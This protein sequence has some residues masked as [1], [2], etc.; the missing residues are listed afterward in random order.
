MGSA[1]RARAEAQRRA[2]GRERSHSCPGPAPPRPKPP[3]PPPRAEPPEKGR[4]RC[5]DFFAELREPLRLPA[6]PPPCPTA[7]RGARPDAGPSRTSRLTS[8]SSRSKA[9]A[10]CVR[11]AGA[12]GS[13]G[14]SMDDKLAQLKDLAALKEQGVLT[15]MSSRLRRPASSTTGSA[16]VRSRRAR[17]LPN[18]G[19][20]PTMESWPRTSAPISPRCAMTCA[21]S[22]CRDGSGSRSAAIPSPTPRPP[23][24]CG[25]HTG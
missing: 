18:G 3:R 4:E 15:T 7:S 1:P 14:T 5:Q 19:S 6:R 10:A 16:A 23:A 8:S 20:G 12:S 11:R 17:G 13:S 22:R 2:A 21:S 24:W 25:S 9:T